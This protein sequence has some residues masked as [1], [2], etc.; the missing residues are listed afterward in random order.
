MVQIVRLIVLYE[1]LKLEIKLMN[2]PQNKVLD[3]VSEHSR[4]AYILRRSFATLFEVD[5]ALFQLNKHATFKAGSAEIPDGSVQGVEYS[6]RFLCREESRPQEAAQRLRR[7]L[8]GERFRNTSL[9]YWTTPK[10]RSARS[11]SG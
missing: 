4:A 9:A 6:D 8:P 3:E 1:N 11:R 10:N 7:A 2:L 5:S